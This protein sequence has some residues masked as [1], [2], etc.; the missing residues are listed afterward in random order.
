MFAIRFTPEAIEDLRSYGKRDRK[1]IM[2][3]IDSCL[4]HEPGRQTR[5]NKKMRPNRLAERE[6][7]IDRF[8]VFYDIDERNALVRIE[9][10]GY[11]RGNRLYV[12]GEEF[13]L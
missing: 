6:L 7:R 13:Q 8:R 5:N 2:D 1:R 12:G 4:K 9:A 10:V 3:N 11:K